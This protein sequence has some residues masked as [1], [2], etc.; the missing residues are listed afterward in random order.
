VVE[1]PP[2][3]FEALVADAL[4]LIPEELGRRMDN[5]V[6]SVRDR[7]PVPGLL[8][9]YEG[10]PLTRRADYG[11]LALPDRITVYREPILRRCASEAE[12]V[13]QVR[14]TVV[15][16][17]AHHFGIGDDRLDELGWA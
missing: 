14:I 10:I 2:D 1:V 13:E 5:V 7:P 16:E 17:V 4:D 15:H 6:V 9:R 11:G 3:R 12:V 8:G